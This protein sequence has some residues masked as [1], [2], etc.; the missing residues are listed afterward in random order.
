[1]DYFNILSKV[2]ENVVK[3]KVSGRYI[4]NEDDVKTYFLT[5]SNSE[6]EDFIDN[7]IS[8]LKDRFYDSGYYIDE[9]KLTDAHNTYDFSDLC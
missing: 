3:I 1:M 8:E 2:K 4:Y 5:L 9:L 6:V 7:G